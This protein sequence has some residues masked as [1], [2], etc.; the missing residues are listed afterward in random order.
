[1]KQTIERPDA[2]LSAGRRG[3]LNMPDLSKS[4]LGPLRTELGK[5]KQ[6]IEA[7]EMEGDEKEKR[8]I[9]DYPAFP[10]GVVLKLNSPR[11]GGITL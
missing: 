8:K 5:Q 10:H 9:Y 11:N 2:S 1:M 3:T 6:K 7:E 4:F